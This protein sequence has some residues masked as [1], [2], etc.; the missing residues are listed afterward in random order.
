MTK[1]QIDQKY[2]S[3]GGIHKLEE[4]RAL[5]ST[6]TSIANH[7]GVCRERASD[8]MNELFDTPYNPRGARREER[9]K[10]AME[11]I[12]QIGWIETKKTFKNKSYLEEA[13]KRYNEQ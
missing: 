9:V 7:F 2:K 10:R 12:R 6:L 13:L 1:N 8:W 11:S 5:Q 4:F 3:K